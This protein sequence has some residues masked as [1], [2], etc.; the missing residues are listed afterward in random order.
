MSERTLVTDRE[1]AVLGGD[2]SDNYRYKV[3]STVR[4]RIDRLADE[5]QQLEDVAPDLHREATDAVCDTDTAQEAD[6]VEEL[7]G[8]LK[9][10]ENR[11]EAYNE[12]P[13]QSE[14]DRDSS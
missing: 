14:N 13:Q 5:I 4:D 8:R 3:R 11:F 12:D 2:G 1:I 6:R 10:L 9:L 7:E